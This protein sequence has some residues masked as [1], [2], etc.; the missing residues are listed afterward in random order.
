M[1]AGGFDEEENKLVAEMVIEFLTAKV[2]HYGP[3]D[4]LYIAVDGV[5][6]MAKIQQ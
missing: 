1:L 6:L 3:T 2:N 5:P 4:V